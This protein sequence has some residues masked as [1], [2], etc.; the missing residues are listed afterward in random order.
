MKS[1][2]KTTKSIVSSDSIDYGVYLARISKFETSYLA[3]LFTRKWIVYKIRRISRNWKSGKCGRIGEVVLPFFIHSSRD[4]RLLFNNCF[5]IIIIDQH[6][7]AIQSW[8]CFAKVRFSGT[9]C[10]AIP[11]IE[12]T[13]S[14]QSVEV[15]PTTCFPLVNIN[16]F[17]M[18][19]V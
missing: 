12:N 6:N 9:F 19:T 1:I 13:A 7:F 3:T 8:F 14:N 15:T 10:D 5:Y 16:D 17:Y 18:Y 11:L 2:N 4:N